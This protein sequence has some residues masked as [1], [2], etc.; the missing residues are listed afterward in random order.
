MLGM[1]RPKQRYSLLEYASIETFYK[2]VS[3]I[4]MIHDSN[5]KGLSPP[6]GWLLI[7]LEVVMMHDGCS[8]AT[9]AHFGALRT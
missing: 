1:G 2:Y 3:K 8:Q 7:T 6:L 4:T 5:G 9:V